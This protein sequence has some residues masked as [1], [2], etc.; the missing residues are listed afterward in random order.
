M[1][2]VWQGV[3]QGCGRGV[4]SGGVVRR[5]DGGHYGLT[6]FMGGQVHSVMCQG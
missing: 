4:V 1:E 6:V 5:R 3:W 2:W